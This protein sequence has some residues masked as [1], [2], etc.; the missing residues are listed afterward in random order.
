MVGTN[1]FL[2]TVYDTD[3]ITGPIEIWHKGATEAM[4]SSFVGRKNSFWICNDRATC[5]VFGC[6]KYRVLN[7]KVK[8]RKILTGMLTVSRFGQYFVVVIA[9]ISAHII[10]LE[11]RS[12]KS[13][14]YLHRSNNILASS[15]D[16][17]ANPHCFVL[18]FVHHVYL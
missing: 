5:C 14:L 13:C 12:Y 7:I 15:C 11:L 16:S 4:A 8:R 6:N 9:S 2:L 10:I 18:H 3:M 1:N 17:V